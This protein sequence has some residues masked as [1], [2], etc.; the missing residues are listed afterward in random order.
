VVNI[1]STATAIPIPAATSS[2]VNVSPISLSVLHQHLRCAEI[3]LAGMISELRK[4]QVQKN[5]P[6]LSNSNG[7]GAMKK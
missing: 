5:K 6:S 1:A 7:G 2:A 4:I 3:V